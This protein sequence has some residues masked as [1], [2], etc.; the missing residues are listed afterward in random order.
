SNASQPHTFTLK[1]NQGKTVRPLQNNSEML[2]KL[3]S[4]G[5]VA[6]EFI[7]IPNG[8]GDQMNAW[9]MKPKNFDPNKKYPL[10]MYQ[11]SGPG[12]QQVT[13]SWD[14]GNGL[15]FSH[16]VQQGYIVACVDGRGTGGRSEEHTS[17]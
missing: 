9:I 12:S 8:A 17:E 11:Y 7:T 10:F 13:N 15:W 6:R 4:D 1:D 2:D 3:K 5:W 16:L 14:G